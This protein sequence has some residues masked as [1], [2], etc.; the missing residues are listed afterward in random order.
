MLF[1]SHTIATIPLAF[2]VWLR[3]WRKQTK[4]GSYETGLCGMYPVGRRTC[5]DAGV[6]SAA[7]V[8]GLYEVS[9]VWRKT[10]WLPSS[11]TPRS[12]SNWVSNRVRTMRATG[13]RV[14]C[15]VRV[16]L[17]TTSEQGVHGHVRRQSGTTRARERPLSY[18]LRQCVYC[19]SRQSCDGLSK[20]RANR[21]N[22]YRAA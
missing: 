19:V 22:R 14:M 2:P 4:W 20:H 13:S 3:L 21:A 5:A 8:F 11:V 1:R 9:R 6:G 12:P 10:Y 18:P 7:V 17:H 15:V 16:E